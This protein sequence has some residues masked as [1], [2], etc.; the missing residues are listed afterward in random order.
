M[1]MTLLTKNKSGFVDG[2][3]MEPYEAD[4]IFPYWKRCNTLVLAWLTRAMESLIAQSF[5]FIENA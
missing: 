4:V 2:S 1:K 3:I 5:I